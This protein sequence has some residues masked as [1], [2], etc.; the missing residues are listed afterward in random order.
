MTKPTLCH[1]LRE[2]NLKLNKERTVN[3]LTNEETL[4]EIVEIVDNHL[5]KC[6]EK[7][8]LRID[9]EEIRSIVTLRHGDKKAASV[10]LAVY[11]RKTEE[12][13]PKITLYID[14]IANYAE[15]IGRE[16]LDILAKIFFT[17]VHHYLTDTKKGSID[18]DNA[19]KFANNVCKKLLKQGILTKLP[20]IFYIDVED[21]SMHYQRLLRLKWFEQWL[22]IS[23]DEFLGED[24]DV[25]D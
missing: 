12:E 14:A 18:Y 2:R 11:T 17:Q 6:L 9:L 16:Y 5:D 15:Y 23:L 4:K 19:E 7:S 3:N 20:P 22:G 25:K 24:K 8:G 10:F 21:P 13:D 1:A